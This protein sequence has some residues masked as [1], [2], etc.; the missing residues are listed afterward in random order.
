[1]SEYQNGKIYAI[2]SNNCINY[3]IGA[4]IK[5]LEIRFN[6]HKNE[7][8]N[9]CTSK[10]IIN[11]LNSYIK[12]LENYPC[13]NRNELLK[14]ESEW[15]KTNIKYVVNKQL[16]NIN[17]DNFNNYRNGYYR[18]ICSSVIKCGSRKEHNISKKHNNYIKNNENNE[19]NKHNENN[20]IINKVK[21]FK[22]KKTILPYKCICGSEIKI[23]CKNAHELTYKHTY[24]INNISNINNIYNNEYK[25]IN[26]KTIKCNCGSIIN[27]KYKYIH[28]N[29]KKHQ[30]YL[31]KIINKKLFINK[32][33]KNNNSNNSN[34]SNSNNS[35]NSK[36]KKKYKVYYRCECSSIIKCSGKN[37][38]DSSSKHI[39]YINT[40][41][42]T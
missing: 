14:R 33:N 32:N 26:D 1:M 27:N 8:S 29:S 24:Y 16:P 40:H 11:N 21:E 42:K 20:K 34:N 18:C 25:I 31:I 15:I 37:E 35:N 38:H 6:Q 12:L 13:N 9:Q 19:N 22:I 23:K 39:K 36:I 4:T 17:E 10:L 7:K 3:Y 28:N 2:Y 41:I 30:N 5:T